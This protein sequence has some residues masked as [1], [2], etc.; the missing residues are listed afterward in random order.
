[1]F[2]DFNEKLAKLVVHYSVDTKPGDKVIIQTQTV[3]EDLAREVYK[4][5]II[6][7]ANILDISLSIPEVSEIFFRYAKDEQINFENPLRK[8]AV[9]MADILINIYSESN[10]SGM[11]NIDPKKI[12]M[13]QKANEETNKIYFE[14]SGSEELKWTICPFPTTAFAQEAKMG[15]IQ[16]KEFV[17]KALALDKPDPVA[18]WKSTEEKQEKVVQILNKGKKMRIVGEDTDI[19]F[20]IEN[21]PWINSCGK[22]NLPDGEV[23]TSPIENMTNGKIRFTYPGIYMGQEVEDI[24]L[25]FKDGKVVNFDAAKGKDLLEQVLG[26]ENANILGELAVGTNY[27]ITNF[28][29]NMLFDEKMGGTIHLA[30]GNGFE[31]SNS[32]N[33]STIHWDILKDMKSEDSVIYLDD[34]AIYKAGKWIIP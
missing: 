16:Y 14:R 32:K 30:L 24:Y 22:K 25:E 6:A 28:T 3:A 19:T 5:L 20:G 1:M 27:G 21:R 7:G 29:K 31:Q 10:L 8:E 18:Y 23:F 26:I 15:T 13:R 12:M 9:K 2:D 4:E 17:Y 11:M 33:R 34:Q